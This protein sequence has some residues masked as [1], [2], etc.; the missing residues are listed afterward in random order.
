MGKRWW[1]PDVSYEK[2]VAL[3]QAIDSVTKTPAGAF[4]EAKAQSAIQDW[5]AHA[6]SAASLQPD[7][8]PLL[9]LLSEERLCFADNVEVE[10]IARRLYLLFPGAE[11][12]YTRRD[13]VSGIR[14]GFNWLYARAWTDEDFSTWLTRGFADLQGKNTAALMLRC[15]DYPRIE[16]AFATYF[17]IVRS[18]EFDSMKRDPAKYI[19]E[20]IGIQSEE[21][22]QYY[23]LNARPLNEAVKGGI[24]HAHRLTKKAIRVWNWL[25]LNKI[26]E[27]P[28]HLGDSAFW[29]K[30]ARIL[31]LIPVSQRRLVGSESD[32]AKLRLHFSSYYEKDA[33]QD[34]STDAKRALRT[35]TVN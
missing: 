7:G 2:C 23:W 29:Q 15:F 30:L 9:R 20:L 18:V 10:E 8:T 21:F 16:R 24:I 27:K 22:A 31:R 1:N 34:G 28:E 33:P 25:P 6:P 35:E 11:I 5:M 13:P 12:V 14:S 26:D 19:G 3:H 17:P 32:I 4:D